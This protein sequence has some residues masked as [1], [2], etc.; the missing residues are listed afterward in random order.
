MIKENSKIIDVAVEMP[1]SILNCTV[2][3]EKQGRI[4]LK[5]NVCKYLE[6]NISIF[7]HPNK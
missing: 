6:A 2:H 1:T 5:L 4:E 3:V 7:A